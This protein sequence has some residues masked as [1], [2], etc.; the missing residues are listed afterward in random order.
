MIAPLPT[1]D[2]VTRHASYRGTHA[3]LTEQESDILDYLL[4]MS[5]NAIDSTEI[6]DFCFSNTFGVNRISQIV[7]Q[8]R[9]KLGDD[10]IQW[11]QGI[12][13]YLPGTD[14]ANAQYRYGITINPARLWWEYNDHRVQLSPNSMDLVDVLTRE[15]GRWLDRQA[16]TGKVW[17]GEMRPPFQVCQEVY[18][19]RRFLPAGLRLTDN[20]AAR[21]KA[22]RL[23]AT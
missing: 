17:P 5:P 15:F 2:P 4:A 14:D 23:E 3:R 19:L 22:Y 8:I 9:R 11:R 20:G 12:G 18:I 13:Y 7:I 21:R 6:A 16:L 10:V 1:L